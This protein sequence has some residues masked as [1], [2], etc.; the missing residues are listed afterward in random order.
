M[1][2]DTLLN[3][4]LTV[5]MFGTIFL[6]ILSYYD[7]IPEK[8]FNE[9][10]SKDVGSRVKVQGTIKQ[11]YLNNNSMSIKLKQECLMDIFLFDKNQN[12][13][14]NDSINVDGTVQEYN[15]KMEIMADKIARSK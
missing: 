15:G 4:A 12:L 7:K 10:T 13:S 3:I 6:L 11:I 5:A 8:N 9:I 2:D 1:K 14:I